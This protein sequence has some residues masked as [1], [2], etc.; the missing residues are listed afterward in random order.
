M[1][2]AQSLG[3]VVQ[4]AVQNS[5]FSRSVASSEFTVAHRLLREDRFDH[6]VHECNVADKYF[7]I[8]YAHNGEQNARLG[9]IASKRTLPRA[10]DRNKVK[11][12]IREAFRRHGIKAKKLDI[13]VLVKIPYAQNDSLKTSELNMLFSRIEDKCATS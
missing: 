3:L 12:M 2:V 10:V 1:A 9:I 8:F 7:K 5:Q 6:V 4:K 11:R 13:V